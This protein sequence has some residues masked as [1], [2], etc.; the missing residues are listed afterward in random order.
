MHRRGYHLRRRNRPAPLR[1][2][3]CLACGVVC[4]SVMATRQG[5]VPQPGSVTI[6]FECGHIMAFGYDL[7][8]RPLTDEEMH[9]VAGDRNIVMA[10]RAIA[11]VRRLKR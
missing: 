5:A 10:Q 2:D 6:C 3:R 4:D 7:R 9:A 11:E 8:L 1:P